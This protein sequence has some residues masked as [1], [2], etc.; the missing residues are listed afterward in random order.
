M[1]FVYNEKGLNR[2]DVDTFET[3]MTTDTLD[4]SEARRQLFKLS[5]RVQSERG[6]VIWVTT[7]NKRSFAIVE[8]QL[9]ESLIETL[10]LLHDPESASKLEQGLE[11]ART[12]RVS[13]HEDVKKA[14]L[15]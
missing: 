10:E 8:P 7:D 1:H 6:T 13:N 15:S 3:A 2:I 5:Q 14:L 12:G 9:M 11:D 4:I